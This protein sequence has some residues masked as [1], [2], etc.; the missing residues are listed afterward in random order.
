MRLV[1][2]GGETLFDY[3]TRREARAAVLGVQPVVRD[4]PVLREVFGSA[5][6]H[7]AFCRQVTGGSH[8]RV[9]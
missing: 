2:A 5:A 8:R 6:R 9:G 3:R 7:L 4:L 1:I